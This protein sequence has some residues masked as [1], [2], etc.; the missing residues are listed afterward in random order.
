MSASS[1]PT[2]RPR[3]AMAA[4]RLTVTLDLPTPPLPDATAYTRVS[5]PGG[6]NEATGCAA[7]SGWWAGQ[8]PRRRP[9]CRYDGFRFLGPAEREWGRRCERGG[10][11]PGRR[12]RERCRLC[13]RRWRQLVGR[14]RRRLR[15][16][17]E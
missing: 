4:A 9:R 17:A 10:R 7:E 13:E 11:R 8:W 6:A 3:A 16:Q 2:D 1:T 5:E 12:R 14:W 15:R